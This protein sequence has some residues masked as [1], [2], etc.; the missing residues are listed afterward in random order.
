MP[1]DRAE[2]LF[3]AVRGSR[4]VIVTMEAAGITTG[5]YDLAGV[6]ALL[7]SGLGD[8]GDSMTGEAGDSKTGEAGESVMGDAGDSVTGDA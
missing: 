3:A 2:D 6:L 7:V 4:R 8:A 5:V 1:L